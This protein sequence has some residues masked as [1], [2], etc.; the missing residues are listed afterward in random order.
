MQRAATTLGRVR[1][2]PARRIATW[3]AGG[4][5]FVLLVVLLT[6]A[7][8]VIATLRSHADL[9]TPVV[10][11]EQV[12]RYADAQV[13]TGNYG[14]WPGMW[15]AQLLRPL[16]AG[17]TLVLWAPALLSVLAIAAL[18][19]EARRLT[20]TLGGLL[21]VLV[22]AAVGPDAWMFLSSWSGRA[23]TWWATIAIA[24]ALVHVASS[25]R[26]RPGAGATIGAVAAVVFAAVVVSGDRLALAATIA[27]LVA[28]AAVLA[29]RSGWR[30]A[31][32]PLGMAV[33]A[34][35]GSLVVRAI[36]ESAGYLQQE[37]P[38]EAVPFTSYGSHVANAFRG[39]MVLWRGAGTGDSDFAGGYAGAILVLVVLGASCA[40]V[41]RLL[42]ARLAERTGARGEDVTAALGLPRDGLEDARTVWM[43]FWLSALGAM[44][45]AFCISNV[46]FDAAGGPVVRYLYGVPFATAAL[47]A[48]LAERRNWRLPVALAIVLA[49]IAATTWARTTPMPP[50]A[51]RVHV[52]DAVRRIA[53]EEGVRRGY[54]SYWAAYPIQLASDHEL[55]MVPVGGCVGADPYRLC[56]MYLH[57]VDRAFQTE[58]RPS[59]VLTDAGPGS[60]PMPAA[61]QLT[62]LPAGLRPRRSVDLGDGLTMH[63]FD[64]DVAAALQPLGPDRP[65]PGEGGP[66]LGP[67]R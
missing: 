6:R 7:G 3:V 17:G 46:T 41:W 55:D 49:A 53:E 42:R 10:L 63:V 29:W 65:A 64:T 14:W 20:S 26:D 15:L 16:P 67:A 27:P 66:L 43:V 56:P 23:P 34:G 40:W 37:F 57:Y 21:V 60:S 50:V 48:G 52:A 51:G 22:A 19:A 32:V 28:V 9:L 5:T 33:A 54:A 36:A 38:V 30:R 4:V 11:A 44:L 62:Q 47:A 2:L 61:D 45:V 13:M 39:L 31:L 18:A 12:H 59:F 25:P 8:D 35:L 1:A 58:D 24:I